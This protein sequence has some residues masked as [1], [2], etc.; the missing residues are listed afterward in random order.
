MC[1][2]SHILRPEG[3]QMSVGVKHHCATPNNHSCGCP[4]P[5][6]NVNCHIVSKQCQSVYDSHHEQHVNVALS[7][8]LQGMFDIVPMPPSKEYEFDIKS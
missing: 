7:A 5:P 6:E 1:Y 4:R 2:T 8:W 3:S